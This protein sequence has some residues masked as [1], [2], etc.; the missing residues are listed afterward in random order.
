MLEGLPL[1]QGLKMLIDA[2]RQ[3][4]SANPP[5]VRISIWR[6]KG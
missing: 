2:R 5:L 1:F 3:E 4:A 6:P